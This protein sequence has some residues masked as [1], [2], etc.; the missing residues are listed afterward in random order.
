MPAAPVPR[1]DQFYRHAELTRL[2]QDVRGRAARPGRAAV[3]RQ[4]LRGPRHLAAHRDP[5]ADRRARRQAGVLGRRQHPRRRAHRQHRLP[6][7]AAPPA[8]ALR[9]QRRD[10]PARDAAARHARRLHLPA[11]EPGRRRTR[12]GRRAAPHPLV[13][14]AVSVRRAGRSTGS[15][16]GRRR[17]RPRADDAHP[18]P[19]RR[20]RR[21]TRS[22]PRADGRRANP[23]SSAASTTA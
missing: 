15:R 3:A 4:E 20:A 21:N 1:F 14:A 22:E 10:R 16:R 7:L 23:A 13:D 12:A 6:V 19:A 2:L 5:A 9:R 11:A 8:H 18:R 17:R